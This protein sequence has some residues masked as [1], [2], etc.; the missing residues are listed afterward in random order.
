MD[1]MAASDNMGERVARLETNLANYAQETADR[2]VFRTSVIESLGT[3]KLRQED[4]LRYQALCD[5]ERAA[6]EKRITA[7]ENYKKVVFYVVMILSGGVT[8]LANLVLPLL[9]HT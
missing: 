9:R 1:K 8:W 7:L 3:I 5:A 6:H 4:A 2:S